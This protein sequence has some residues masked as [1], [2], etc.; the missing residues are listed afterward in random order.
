[1]SKRTPTNRPR[2]KALFA[3]ALLILTGLVLSGPVRAD[4]SLCPEVVPGFG[5]ASINSDGILNGLDPWLDNLLN[6]SG[7]STDP[8][9][10]PS[11]R[12]TTDRNCVT[13]GYVP[14]SGTM[15]LTHR[16]G[17]VVHLQQDSHRYEPTA[18]VWING[19][20]EGEWYLPLDLGDIDI[21]FRYQ[22]RYETWLGSV[23][24]VLKPVAYVQACNGWTI[25]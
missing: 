8:V 15:Q 2:R 7:R 5:C 13:T 24:Q 23:R 17:T 20:S 4:A 12:S 19:Q 21:L 25:G 10:V 3:A 16:N 14:R 22:Y 18:H 11:S 6:G 9:H 1:M